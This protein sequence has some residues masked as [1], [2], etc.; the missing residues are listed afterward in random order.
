MLHDNNRRVKQII[1]NKTII[2]IVIR[3][4][5][6]KQLNKKVLQ[7]INFVRKKKKLYLPYELVGMNGKTPTECYNNMHEKS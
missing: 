1:K 5:Q 7:D 4:I 3:Y 6:I 2:D